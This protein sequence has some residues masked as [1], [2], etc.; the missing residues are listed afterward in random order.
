MCDDFCT[1]VLFSATKNIKLSGGTKMSILFLN[2]FFLKM[3]IKKKHVQIY[4]DK[5]TG[6]LE[7]KSSVFVQM[8]WSKMQVKAETFVYKII[9]NKF[10]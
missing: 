4:T 1:K 6:V 3:T 10:W 9:K 8:I 2:F 7:L 5:S